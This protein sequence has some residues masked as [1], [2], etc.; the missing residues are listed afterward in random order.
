[1]RSSRSYPCAGCSRRSRRM[2]GRRKFRGSPGSGADTCP[3]LKA[4]SRL[5]WRIMAPAVVVAVAVRGPRQL[6]ELRGKCPLAD[7]GPAF[8][9]PKAGGDALEVAIAHEPLE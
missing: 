7:L 4:A 2:H 3:L 1:M 6:G 5:L 9:E 8:G